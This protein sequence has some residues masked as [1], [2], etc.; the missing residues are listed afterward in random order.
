MFWVISLSRRFRKKALKT[1]LSQQMQNILC[2]SFMGAP[3]ECAMKTKSSGLKILTLPKHFLLASSRFLG[4]LMEHRRR[5]WRQIRCPFEGVWYSLFCSLSSGNSG[6]K[7]SWK[8]FPFQFAKF[9]SIDSIS[10][11]CLVAQ[12]SPIISRNRENLRTK[13]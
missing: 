5:Q 13:L 1:Y 4:R 12:V 7:R 6:V 8:C 11:G 2:F 9:N 10:E 3:G